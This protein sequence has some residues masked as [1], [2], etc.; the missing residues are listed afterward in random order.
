MRRDQDVTHN[1]NSVENVWR[2]FKYAVRSA[3]V[4]V[5]PKYRQRYLD[6]FSF[7]ANHREMQNEMFD[8]LIG[9]V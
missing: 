4:H 9:S 7:R 5:S 2:Q 6:E 8:L 3:H 1:T